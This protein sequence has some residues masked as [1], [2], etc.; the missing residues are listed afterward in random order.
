MSDVKNT[1]FG[2]MMEEPWNDE[3]EQLIDTSSVLP[4]SFPHTRQDQDDPLSLTSDQPG[5]KYSREVVER[6]PRRGSRRRKGG[7]V[8]CE[9]SESGVKKRIK[10]SSHP[11]ILP[12]RSSSPNPTIKILVLSPLKQD[13]LIKSEVIAESEGDSSDYH[14]QNQDNLVQPSSSSITKSPD[15]KKKHGKGT[16]ASNSAEK[17]GGTKKKKNL[18]PSKKRLALDRANERRRLRRANETPAQREERRKKEKERTR[19]LRTTRPQPKKREWNNKRAEK[20]R[21]A[22]SNETEAEREERLRKRRERDQAKI[23]GETESEKKERLTSKYFAREAKKAS[24]TPEEAEQAEFQHKMKIYMSYVAYKAKFTPEEWKEKQKKKKTFA[25]FP[26]ERKK[27]IM[28]K[29][30]AYM[31]RIPVERKKKYQQTAVRNYMNRAKQD[32]A[33]WEQLYGKMIQAN[34]NKIARETP[35]ERQKR[36]LRYKVYQAKRKAKLQLEKEGGLTEEE[37]K[38]RL[39]EVTWQVEEKD[40]LEKEKNPREPVEYKPRKA[41]R[42]PRKKENWTTKSNDNEKLPKIDSSFSLSSSQPDPPQQLC[43]SSSS[44]SSTQANEW[45]Q[46]CNDLGFEIHPVPTPS[47]SSMEDVTSC[48]GDEPEPEDY[49]HFDDNDDQVIENENMSEN[50]ASSVS[51]GCSVTSPVPPPSPPPPLENCEG[52]GAIQVKLEGPPLSFQPPVISEDAGSTSPSNS[53]TRKEIKTEE[54]SAATILTSTSSHPHA[55]D[56]PP[57]EKKASKL[58]MCEECGKCL[59]PQSMKVHK[60]LFHNPSKVSSFKCPKCDKEFASSHRLWD[61]YL[62]LHDEEKK[63]LAKEVSTNAGPFIC[64]QC[65]KKYSQKAKY[66]MHVKQVHLGKRIICEVCGK[67]EQSQGMLWRHKIAKH[68]ELKTPPPKGMVICQ[69]CSEPVLRSLLHH[70]IKTHPDKYQEFIDSGA[71]MVPKENKGRKRI[72]CEECDKELRQSDM[73]RHMRSVHGS[74][75]IPCQHC[76]KEFKEGRKLTEHI[77]RVH[78]IDSFDRKVDAMKL[79]KEAK[80]GDGQMLLLCSLCDEKLFRRKEIGAHL[81]STHL[82][83]FEKLT[84]GGDDG[85]CPSWK[86]VECEEE[87]CFESEQ[88]FYSHV[89]SCHPEKMKYCSQ[90]NCYKLFP[91]KH[92]LRVHHGKEHSH[93]KFINPLCF[94]GGTYRRPRLRCDCCMTIF[95]RKPE[96]MEH[97]K[98][99]HPE[100]YWP[101]PH[102]QLMFYTEEQLKET[103]LGSCRR[104]PEV[105]RPKKV[106]KGKRGRPKR[107]QEKTVEI[108]E[109]ESESENYGK[110]EKIMGIASRSLATKTRSSSRIKVERKKNKSR[111]NTRL[112][113]VATDDQKLKTKVKV[114]LTRL[115]KEQIDY[116]VFSANKS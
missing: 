16:G 7:K 86:C 57:P 113:N 106:I 92:S 37:I 99:L 17:S 40:R 87:P 58:T 21:I 38:R 52:A 74:E 59:Y 61:H 2:E 80:D 53:R 14:E 54:E 103:H 28:E 66:E 45:L 102:C 31:E 63:A 70:V 89:K 33:K 34:R 73:K 62:N 82:D 23:A 18:D 79:I 41:A 110:K 65:G 69:Y 1:R 8:N 83:V 25:A 11:K 115:T 77:R 91:T 75:A 90:L 101:C 22:R 98:T 111:V 10:S 46:R 109:T 30:K 94:E 42:K 93:A 72:K 9:E 81:L 68:P 24:L 49:D 60:H 13:V 114:L 20:M 76:G 84:K 100:A 6:T 3:D 35:E 108:D 56:P 78:V 47:K 67:E 116:Y 27:K 71:H 105:R 55:P 104:N 64:E 112:K 95:L 107:L 19:K 48:V 15:A 85:I 26:I 50:L 36:L 51:V 32:P 97:V 88:L 43:I 96:L 4:S 5:P 12:S 44:S 29:R 39:D